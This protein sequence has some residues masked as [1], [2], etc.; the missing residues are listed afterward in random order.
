MP[1][2]VCNME[3]SFPPY[4]Y[5]RQFNIWGG[6][7]IWT[8][9][10]Y[11]N[12]GKEQRF[13]YNSTL[14]YRLW[15]Q[16]NTM[17]WLLLLSDRHVMHVRDKGRCC[18]SGFHHPFTTAIKIFS[19]SCE[20]SFHGLPLGMGKLGDWGWSCGAFRQ[21]CEMKSTMYIRDWKMGSRSHFY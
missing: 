20:Y 14:H 9:C 1:T 11:D 21:Q 5:S 15:P 19:I 2:E 17:P 16:R 12:Q 18:R 6:G 7:N 3:D 13:G 8:V 4:Q 10:P